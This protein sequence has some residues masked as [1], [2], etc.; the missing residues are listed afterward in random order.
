MLLLNTSFAAP[1]ITEVC[2][3]EEVAALVY[4][5]EFEELVHD[6]GRRRKRFVA[7]RE[8]EDPDGRADRRSRP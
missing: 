1:Q 7:W 3:R 4:D 5:E 8:G 2:K 6:A